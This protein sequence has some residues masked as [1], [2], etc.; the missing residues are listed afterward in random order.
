MM[1]DVSRK[2]LR[3]FAE[4]LQQ[5]IEAG[6]AP[7]EA[8]SAPAGDAGG[9][10]TAAQPRPAPPS[11]PAAKPLSGLALVGTVVGGMFRRLL[12]RLHLRRSA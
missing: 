11:P 3:Q 2:L 8:A 7:P 10:A 12:A 5:A 1:Q 9:P 6:D 4:C